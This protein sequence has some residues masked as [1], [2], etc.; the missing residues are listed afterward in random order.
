LAIYGKL[1]VAEKSKKEKPTAIAFLAV[2]KQFD[3]YWLSIASTNLPLESSDDKCWNKVDKSYFTREFGE[4]FK[5]L[6]APDDRLTWF[7]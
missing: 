1:D 3:W 6:Q 4:R 2:A 7:M 5:R